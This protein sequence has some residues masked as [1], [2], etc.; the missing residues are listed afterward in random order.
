MSVK[1]VL[2][3]LPVADAVLIPTPFYGVI[4]EDL[5]LY[6]NV[7]LF[8]VPLACE[9]GGLISYAI[10][11]FF[12]QSPAHSVLFIKCDGAFCSLVWL[13][14][15]YF[16]FYPQADGKDSRPFHLTVERLEEALKSAKQQVTQRHLFLY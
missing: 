6:S 16:A 2:F 11:V 14:L 9:V 13:F 4:T 3:C 1:T 5:H 7:K 15:F 8:H 10:I 12:F